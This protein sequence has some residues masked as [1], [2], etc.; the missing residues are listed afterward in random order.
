[1]L[2]TFLGT[3]AEAP[4]DATNTAASTTLTVTTTAAMEV[5]TVAILRVGGQV[6][7][8]TAGASSWHTSISDG[9][10]NSYVK[11]AE[12]SNDYLSFGNGVTGS[13]WWCQVTT[14]VPSGTV[15]TVTFSVGTYGRMILVDAYDKGDLANTVEIVG[16]ASANGR[17]TASTVTVSG[18]VEEDLTWIG[19]GSRAGP[20]YNYYDADYTTDHLEANSGGNNGANTSGWGQYRTQAN[21]ADTWACPFWTWHPIPY[22]AEWCAHLVVFAVRE[23]PPVIVP[24]IREYQV[25][26][27]TASHHLDLTTTTRRPDAVSQDYRLAYA[28]GPV[29]L[30]DL[31]DGWDTWVWRARAEPGAVYLARENDARTGWNAEQLLTTYAGAD[32]VELDLAFT[33]EGTAVVVAERATGTAGAAQVHVYWYNP[34]WAILD[35]Q[36]LNVGNGRTPR[37]VLDLFPVTVGGTNV[38]P[39]D[40]DVQVFYMKPGTGMVRREQSTAYGTE[41]PG[42]LADSTK[43][44]LERAYR[45]TDRRVSVS[46]SQRNTVTGRYQLSRVNSKR[47]RDSLLSRPSFI[48]QVGGPAFDLTQSG[49]QAFSTP[50]SSTTTDTWQLGVQVVEACDAVE[51]EGRAD[52]PTGVNP[53]FTDY[54]AEFTGDY[55]AGFPA[56]GWHYFAVSLTH[57]NGTC[58]LKA[59]RVRARKTVGPSTCYSPWRYMVLSTAYLVPFSDYTDESV[60]CDRDVVMDIPTRLSHWVRHGMVEAIRETNVPAG[61]DTRPAPCGVGPYVTEADVGPAGLY[62]GYWFIGGT[63][64]YGTGY[65]VPTHIIYWSWRVRPWEPVDFSD[66]DGDYVGRV[67]GDVVMGGG[68]ANPT[69]TYDLPGTRTPYQFPNDQGEFPE[70]PD[71]I[72][73]VGIV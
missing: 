57:G 73:I 71:S 53:A 41:Y 50:T 38:C 66:P 7:S 72:D 67:L 20:Y 5:G 6:P 27:E 61:P 29:A 37:C 60:N 25:D 51:V 36:W 70:E 64:N 14:R 10:G 22:N 42:A 46:Y 54:Q 63:R 21:A 23:P 2:L 58:S 65:P 31:S 30:A 18:M 45:T 34:H 28:P 39:P 9:L 4:T 32:I 15:L 17:S 26:F 44:Y 13:V 52:Y 12:Q 35:Y 19:S 11:I 47:Y 33:E 8:P 62:P 49:E 68:G 55:G 59:F 16:Q 24:G 1:M 56:A 48:P 69:R 3:I 43:V 40:A